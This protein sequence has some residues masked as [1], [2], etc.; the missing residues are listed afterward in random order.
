MLSGSEYKDKLG[1]EG[2]FR[3]APLWT[4]LYAAYDA[5]KPT[6]S[7]FLDTDGKHFSSDLSLFK[8][9]ASDLTI[10]GHDMPVTKVVRDDDGSA[11][12]EWIAK[13]DGD[14]D[15]PAW[16]A[17]SLLIFS[18]GGTCGSSCS[19]LTNVSASPSFPSSQARLP[20]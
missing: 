15:R 19:L 5:L 9:K 6:T 8:N 12:Q 4:K 20:R 10:N 18:N 7:S 2:V 11:V 3:V 1:F 16:N 17:D 13:A 14:W